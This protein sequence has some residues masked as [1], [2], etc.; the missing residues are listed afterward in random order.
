MAR[1]WKKI[2]RSDEDYTGKVTGTIDG[3][4]VADI[5]TGAA[6]GVAVKVI[7]DDAFDG[8][9]KLK[10]SNAVDELKNANTTKSDV[11]LDN[12]T[13]HAQIK[14]DGSNAPTILKNDQISISAGGA[15][16][17]A[18]GGVVTATGVGAIKTDGANAPDIL[19]NAQISISAAG[20]LSNAG[21][22]TV[23]AS[24]LGAVKT[25]LTNAPSTIKNANT[26]KADVGLNNVLDRAQTTTFTQASVP[27]S[28]AA[29]D[30]WID[31][32]DGNKQYIATSAG[33]DQVTSGEWVVRAP[34]KAVVGLGNVT[35]DAQIKTDGSN[36]PSTLTNSSVS[37]S[38]GGV[39]SGGGGGTVTAT[40]VGAIKTDG[41]NAPNILKNAQISISSG[42]V[43]SG[44]GGGTV[45][46]S[47]VGAIKTDAS[48][49]PNTLK[50]TQ[51]TLSASGGTVSINNAGGGSIG[52]PDIG[53]GNV[54]NQALT[55]VSGKIKLDGAAQTLDADKVGGK[56]VSETET[57]AAT[58]A[59]GNILDGAPAGLRTLN[60]LAAALNDDASFNTTVTNSIATK[61]PAPLALTS[62]DVDGDSTFSSAANTPA[63]LIVG[64]VGVFGGNQYVVVDI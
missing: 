58:L 26:T 9:K 52:K 24:G 7:T 13:N 31:T 15:L 62:E 35:N 46:A 43:L 57:A 25:D 47:G 3:T 27:T 28:T 23:S 39:L 32:D 60:E 40:G 41:A 6:A 38:S 36:A 44:A 18:G 56:T 30:I 10:A 61:G 54:I 53:L 48:N 42:G 5:K 34:S 14:T 45:T 33:N 8:N 50:N 55:V 2:Q 11:G 20:V 29:G 51:I 49:A 19:K 21:G 64:Q 63:N 1:Q 17:G 4:S 12:V 37:I 22:G 16:S 59:E